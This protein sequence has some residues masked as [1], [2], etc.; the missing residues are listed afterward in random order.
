MEEMVN[1]YNYTTTTTESAT[2]QPYTAKASST[3]A[4]TTTQWGPIPAMAPLNIPYLRYPQNNPQDLSSHPMFFNIKKRPMFFNIKKRR[5]EQ[6]IHM[7]IF[8][9]IESYDDG[10]LVI[11]NNTLYL[12]VNYYRTPETDQYEKDYYGSNAQGA[13]CFN[14]MFVYTSSEWIVD[15]ADSFLRTGADR[16]NSSKHVYVPLVTVSPKNSDMFNTVSIS[17]NDSQPLVS[18]Y[19]VTFVLNNT[20]SEK[21]PYEKPTRSKVACGLEYEIKTIIETVSGILSIEFCKINLLNRRKA[22]TDM[23]LMFSMCCVP[24]YSLSTGQPVF[25]KVHT[26]NNFRPLSKKETLS[27]IFSSIWLPPRTHG[28]E[29]IKCTSKNDVNDEKADDYYR[30][31]YYKQSSVTRS[32][33]NDNE[34]HNY[35]ETSSRK[36]TLLGA[37]IHGFV[38]PNYLSSLAIHR[39]SVIT[40]GLPDSNHPTHLVMTELGATTTLKNRLCELTEPANLLQAVLPECEIDSN[41][42]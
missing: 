8:H 36:D 38:L 24:M 5:L 42:R 29:F 37:A 6:L 18:K 27:L 33:Y 16:K 10:V 4:S 28:L 15:A 11:Q 3:T 2:G 20:W 19:N 13:F 35:Q 14:A 17:Q 30:L 34:L 25:L 7:L 39:L 31:Y 32:M 12:R 22:A 40:R 41:R 26:P 1:M 23:V 21:G 9:E